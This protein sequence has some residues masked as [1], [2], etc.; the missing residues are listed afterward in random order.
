[1]WLQVLSHT[2][3]RLRD[4]HAAGFVHCDIR[5][6]HIL[7]MS[8]QNRWTVIDFDKAAAI[9]APVAPDCTLDYAAPEVV[10]AVAGGG[11]IPAQ[12]A[13]DAWALGVVSFE[14][15]TGKRALESAKD[16]QASVRSGQS[17]I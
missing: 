5:P 12:P 4:I 3:T 10:A 8:R 6:V 11:A 7:L 13:M 16:G 14:L 15:L 9:G 17:H 2:A 1:M